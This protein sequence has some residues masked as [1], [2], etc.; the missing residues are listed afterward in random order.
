VNLTPTPGVGRIT[1]AISDDGDVIV[2]VGEE[3]VYESVGDV[4]DSVSGGADSS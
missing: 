4:T 2:C 3:D 1:V